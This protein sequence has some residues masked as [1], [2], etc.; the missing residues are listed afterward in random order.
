[1]YIHLVG[2]MHGGM[3]A[4]AAAGARAGAQRES[5]RG[6][7]TSTARRRS[8]G[9]GSGGPR[10]SS[11]GHEEEGEHEDDY[12]DEHEHE[13]PRPDPSAYR[14]YIS[15]VYIY[16]G[17]WAHTIVAQGWFTDLILCVTVLAGIQIGAQ[18]YEEIADWPGWPGIDYG[19]FVV[20][21]TEAVLKLWSQPLKP[22]VYFQVHTTPCF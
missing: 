12:N 11:V 9:D 6:R 17:N 4:A 21:A 16:G 8:V 19:I 10:Y 3:G 1:L 13:A 5:E 15:R 20:F 22:W 7:A 14:F 2:V 18:T